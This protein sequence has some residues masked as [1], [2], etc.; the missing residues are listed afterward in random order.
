[1]N[2]LQEINQRILMHAG[3]EN[4]NLMLSLN[5]LSVCVAKFLPTPSDLVTTLSGE[6]TR[7]NAIDVY[8]LNLAYLQFARQTCRDV[9]HGDFSGLIVLRMTRSQAI[10]VA[11]LSNQQIA[12]LAR[13]W[14]GLLI[15][16]APAAKRPVHSFHARAMPHYSAAFLAATA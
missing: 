4:A 11:D 1:M 2:D 7:A 8:S 15:E 14:P 6:P 5:L 3:A 13:R 9:K 10:A 12:E 16:V